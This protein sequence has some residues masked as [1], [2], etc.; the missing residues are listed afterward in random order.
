MY[1]YCADDDTISAMQLGCTVQRNIR[2]SVSI[3]T[4]YMDTVVF[5]LGL[6]GAGKNLSGNKAED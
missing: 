3:H 6:D 4:R 1:L 5:G 2:F